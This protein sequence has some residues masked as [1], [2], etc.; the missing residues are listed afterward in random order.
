MLTRKVITFLLLVTALTSAIIVSGQSAQSNS[1]R[2]RQLRQEIT[3][4]ETADVPSDL[5]DLNRSKLI[6]RRAELRTL[7]KVEIDNLRKHRD[8][9]GSVITPEETQ[10]I[11]DSLRSYAAEIDKLGVD[12]KNDLAAERSEGNIPSASAPPPVGQAQPAA[13][14]NSSASPISRAPN[15]SLTNGGASSPAS[16]ATPLLRSEAKLDVLPAA[17]S[18]QQGT[19]ATLDCN[20]VLDGKKTA[21]ELDNIVCGLARDIPQR[22][23]RGVTP[24]NELVMANDGFGLMEILIAKK[25]TPKFLVEAEEV[26]LDKQVGGAPAN[27]GSTSLVVKGGV[28]AILGF[29]VENGGLTQSVN[30][31]SITFRGNPVG[32]INA[33]QNRGFVTS[34]KADE[35]DPILR[36][37]NKTSF[38]FTFNTDRGPQPGVFTATKQQLSSFSTRFEFVN[39]RKPRLYIKDWE[40][41][42]HTKAQNLANVINATHADLIDSSN[43]GNEKWIDPKMQAWFE[44]TQKQLRAASDAEVDSVL[45]AR[46]DQL[47]IKELLPATIQVLETIEQALGLYMEGR[48]DVLNKINSGTL[49]TFEYLNKREINAPDTSNFNFIA[50]KGTGGGKVDFTF[51]GSLTMF[52][53]LDILRNFIKLHPTL[54]PA[55]RLRDFQFA[56]QIDVPLGKPTEFGNIVLFAAGRYQRLLQN[57]TTDLGAILPNTKG[58]IAYLQMGFKVPLKGTGF[59]IPL[60]VTFANRSELVKE[61]HIRGNIGFT[62]DLDSLFAKLKPF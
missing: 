26:R 41:F 16:N 5:I 17:L 57:A 18:V 43:P 10:K 14:G 24:K 13:T 8:L 40:D 25:A 20:G 19:N 23:S 46:L 44:E 32:M 38:A 36:F 52:N 53:N 28:P 2:I 42:L 7:L 45:Q 47:P 9:L 54:P 27:T 12:I 33:F 35:N 30:G 48:D 61:K 39:R 21:S 62:L 60:S 37:L 58:D 3:K 49:V 59:K 31:S 1:E 15:S 22:R 29:A 6:E 56:G 51:N 55:R 11:D 34:A 4:R 50:E